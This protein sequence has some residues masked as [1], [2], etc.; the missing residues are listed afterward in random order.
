MQILQYLFQ[1]AAADG[2]LEARE[3]AVLNQISDEMQIQQADFTH[4]KNA[5]DYMYSRRYY[6]SGNQY[7][8]SVRRSSSLENAYAVLGMKS[9]DSDAEIKAAYRRLAIANHPDKVQHLGQT[10]HD[11]AEKR[12]S[13]ISEAYNKIK[14]ERNL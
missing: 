11:E 6:S 7:S 5:Y 1:L 10:A 4:L 3:L 9:T 8:S 2:V 14:K 13:Q 12:F